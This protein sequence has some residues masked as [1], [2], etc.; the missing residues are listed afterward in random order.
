MGWWWRPPPTLEGG[1]WW[2][3]LVVLRLEQGENWHHGGLVVLLD[4]STGLERPS[5]NKATAAGGTQRR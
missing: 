1:Q 3:S 5:I 2:D 4:Q